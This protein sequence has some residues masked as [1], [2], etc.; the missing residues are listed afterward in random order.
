MT[1][2]CPDV[3]KS[4]CPDL[5]FNVQLMILRRQISM[6]PGIWD[7]SS[8]INLLPWQSTMPVP[9]RPLPGQFQT[10][11]DGRNHCRRACQRID[12]SDWSCDAWHMTSRTLLLSNATFLNTLG[13]TQ[14]PDSLVSRWFSLHLTKSELTKQAVSLSVYLSRMCTLSDCSS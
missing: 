4:L 6:V 3:A 14:Q 9:G 12:G 8:T 7:V 10:E 1:L 13:C 2:A 5:M 11:S